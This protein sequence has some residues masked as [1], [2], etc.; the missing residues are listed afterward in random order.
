MSNAIDNQ[1]LKP[2]GKGGRNVFLPV[3]GG[4]HI[5][6]GTMQSQLTATAMLVPTSTASSGPCIGMSTHEQ[7]ATNSADSALRCQILTD[8]IFLLKNSGTDPVAEGTTLF[9]AIVYAENDHTVSKTNGG[10]Q[11]AA[12]YF[13]GMEPDGTVRVYISARELQP[14]DLTTLATSSGAG[15]VGILDAGNFTAQTTVEGAL[16]EIYQ[17]IKSGKVLLP[18]PLPAALV[19]GTPM[20]AFADNAGASAP[21]ISITDSKAFG[22]R[23]NNFATQ[24]AVWTAVALPQD[25]DTS[26][27]MVVHALASKTGATV[28]DATKFTVSMFAQ[29]PAALDDA[30]ADLGG[31]TTAM[32][33]NAV[34]KTVQNVTLSVA[35]PPTP[36]AVC[37]MSIK[38]KDGTLGTDDVILVGL[39][40][41]Y[42]RKAITS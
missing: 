29:V 12:G 11:Q 30:G 39:W 22:I 7:D 38:P 40:I 14:V 19:A 5:Y 15:D 17:A 35:V 16:A 24:T 42:K 27:P 26:A 37:S 4:T 8:Q 25:L 28:G 2:Y 9:G 41:E 33:G 13:Q 23:W 18:V 1:P 34:A 21:G 3:D 31:D 10:S 20:A 32:V 6:Q 36:P